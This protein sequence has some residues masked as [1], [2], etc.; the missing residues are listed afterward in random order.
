MFFQDLPIKRKV[1]GVIMLTSIIVLVLTATAFMI[2]DYVTYKDILRRDIV[3]SAGIAANSGTAALMFQDEASA[4]QVL[5]GLRADPN[6]IAA[7]YYDLK[8]KLFVRYPSDVPLSQFPPHPG[9]LGVRFQKDYIDM[10]DTV[11]ERGKPVGTLYV[12]SSL[13]PLYQRLRL[14]AGIALL[15]FCT[16]VLVAFLISSNLQRRITHPILALAEFA[17]VVS[18]RRD[19]SIRARKM[20]GD[21]LGVLTDAFNLML[22]R[23]HEQTMALR[24]RE[25]QLRL[26]I[27]GARGGTWDWDLKTG[28][29]LWD[30]YL[31]SL[32]GLKPGQFHGSLD[33]FLAIV[34]PDDRELVKKAADDALRTKT[35]LSIEYRVIWP[36]KSVH[37][38][39][40]R[41]RVA[42]DSAGRPVRFVGMGLD[43]TERKQ[44]EEVRSFLAAIVNS[45][46]DAIIGKNLSSVVVSWNAGAERMF[47]Y[48]EA[49][50]LGQPIT[51]LLSPDRPDEELKVLE[52]VKRGDTRHFETVRIRKD[53][54]A[55]D[56]SVTVSPIRNAAGQLIGISSIA[57]DIT[58]RKRSQ[59]ALERHAAVLREQ[60]QMLDLANVMARDLEDRII[61][62]NTG[63][64]KMYGWS[65]SDA[66]GSVSHKLLRTE[67][68]EPPETIR[69][70]LFHEGHWEGEL[71][72]FDKEGRRMFVSSQWVLHRD[73]KG[74]PAAI[75]EINN[76]I[77]QRREAEEQVFRMNQQLEQRVEERTAELIAANRELEAFTYSVAHDL[78][79]PLRHIDA[80]ARI[81]HEDFGSK[82]PPDAER[83]L[84]NIRHGSRNMSRLVDDLLN[85][86]RVGRQELKRQTVPLGGLVNEVMVDLKTETQDRSIEWRI[87]PLPQAECDSGLMKQV[88]ANL[89][90]NAVK[91]TRPRKVAIIEV[92]ADRKNGQTTFFVRDN[93]VGFNM[94][95]SDKLFGVFQRLHRSEEF[96]GTGVGLAT[97]DRIV[98]K[99]GGVVWAEAAPD[100]G[101]TF[102]FTIPSANIP[103]HS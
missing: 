35:G 101:A 99:H 77:T 48:S 19:Y 46:D 10:Y 96:E 63:M 50:M 39:G 83:Y 53:G 95:Y 54:L 80:F 88:F 91:Y 34:H 60:A 69:A 97:V 78:R 71:I 13:S 75:L 52:D 81:L 58:D 20:S 12:R 38:L 9:Q 21:E 87:H 33:E 18:E 43:I 44:A 90:S 22:T 24:E 45:S 82:L 25:E 4:E 74:E 11:A 89:L 41:G 102:F 56:V 68:P 61:L 103:E 8:G 26:T 49:E 100:K 67:F 14:Y 7:A 47:G 2:Y 30:D 23:I 51:R 65:K 42:L 5:S 98:R 64:E 36:D 29:I 70:K 32:F 79:A 37:F 57:R 86:A 85:L 16:S 93:G 84:E 1:I 15:V 3:T 72:H 59:A 40:A 73:S 94:K 27:E 76:D 66:L 17:R 55:I 31:H 92:G 62:W 6:I 28:K